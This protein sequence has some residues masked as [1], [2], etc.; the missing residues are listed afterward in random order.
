MSSS[1]QSLSKELIRIGILVHTAIAGASFAAVIQLASREYLDL[2]CQAMK[3][4][5]GYVQVL[6]NPEV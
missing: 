5:C 1:N 4:A 6:Q 2:V 3:I